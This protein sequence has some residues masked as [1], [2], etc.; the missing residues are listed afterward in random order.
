MRKQVVLTISNKVIKLTILEL[1]VYSLKRNIIFGC[2]QQFT[3]IFCD[4]K[5]Y[6][7]HFLDEFLLADWK[8]CDFRY[9]WE[10]LSFNSKKSLKFLS[11]HNINIRIL[12]MHIEKD[13]EEYI[14]LAFGNSGIFG[15]ELP[16]F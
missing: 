9:F 7:T 12:F 16:K 15:H 11:W 13:F 4:I 8:L 5:P 3:L 10:I 6:F 2:Y 1:S 14:G